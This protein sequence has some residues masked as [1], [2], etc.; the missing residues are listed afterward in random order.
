KKL[1]IDLLSLLFV[2]LLEGSLLRKHQPWIPPVEPSEEGGNGLDEKKDL[3]Q[4][5]TWALLGRYLSQYVLYTGPST[6]WLLS[7]DVAGKLTKAIFAKLTMGVNLGGIKLIR[8]Y[9]EVT[10]T[11]SGKAEEAEKKKEETELQPTNLNQSFSERKKEYVQETIESHDYENEQSEEERVI[12]HLVLVIHGIGQKLGERME[13]IN[14]V[15]DVNVLRRTIKNTFATNPPHELG[16]RSQTSSSPNASRRNSTPTPH[17]GNGVQVLPIQWRQEIKFG[18]ACNNESIQRDLGLPDAEDGQTTMDEITL[19]GVP[20]IRLMI[21][22]VLMDV[23]LYMTPSYREQMINTVT[24]ESNRVYSL[25]VQRNPHFLEVGGKVSIYGHSLGSVL[26]FDILCHQ[27][28]P[29]PSSSMGIFDDGANIDDKLH[30]S[31]VKLDFPVENFF[32][33]GS[34]IGLFLLLKGV[35]IS[36]RK[37]AENKKTASGDNDLG[38]GLRLSPAASPIPLCYPAVEN[39][40]NIFHR[41][42]PIA[43]KLEPLISR[44]YSAT[45]KPAL[46]PYHKGGLKAVHIGLQEFG[47][48]IASKATTMYETVKTVMFARNLLNRVHADSGNRKV[49]TDNDRDGGTATSTQSP[50]TASATGNLQSQSSLNEHENDDPIGA[51]KLKC[52][53]STGRVDYCLQEGILD[54]SYINAITVHLSYWS[55]SD[56]TYFLL[57]ELYRTPDEEV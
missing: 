51:A 54:V 47:S 9:A 23:L 2:D 3:V 49:A 26:A 50:P 27:V 37:F 5:K 30:K 22:D 1:M 43:Y 12:D 4:E 41:A 32:A 8:G 42:D 34:P 24:R 21:S 56:V 39:I 38:M 15:H 53:N 10:K 45:L 35:K 55:D 18:M 28:P 57:R 36:S 17:R 13:A 14:F 20:T 6:A 40:Y 25:F 19:D 33:V 48:G 7:D 46:I 29:S 44:R 52:I 11:L 16:S 31:L